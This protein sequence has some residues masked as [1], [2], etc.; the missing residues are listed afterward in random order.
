MHGSATQVKRIEANLVKGKKKAELAP[1]CLCWADFALSE[2][3]SVYTR[4]VH[5]HNS[6]AYFSFPF[7]FSLQQ[8]SEA[9]KILVQFPFMLCLPNW[10][11]TTGMA[12]IGS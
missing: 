3:S 9:R 12:G 2:K 11:T 7:C 6:C 8:M 4:F 10:S 1:F 5:N